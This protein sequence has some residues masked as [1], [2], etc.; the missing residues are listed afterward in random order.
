MSVMYR[1]I[2][3]VLQLEITEKGKGI[4]KL[5]DSISNLKT[6]FP[7]LLEKWNSIDEEYQALKADFE[8]GF[9]KPLNPDE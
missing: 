8:V 4:E 1:W 6:N 9:V 7:E 2:L 3:Q 5:K